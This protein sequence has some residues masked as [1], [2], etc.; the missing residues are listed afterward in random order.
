MEVD[1]PALVADPLTK[2]PQL[3]EFLGETFSNTDEEIA[4]LVKPEL[5]RQQGDAE[6]VS[7]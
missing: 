4:S 3:R 7:S 1:F 2:I 6:Q 5:F